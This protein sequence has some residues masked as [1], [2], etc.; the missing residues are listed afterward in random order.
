[1]TDE[2]SVYEDL[3]ASISNKACDVHNPTSRRD[4]F[5]PGR[6]TFHILHG[7]HRKT[8]QFTPQ[9]LVAFVWAQTRQTPGVNIGLVVTGERM[10]LMIIDRIRPI[11]AECDHEDIQMVYRFNQD[12]VK[13]KNNSELTFV[14]CESLRSRGLKS[15]ITIFQEIVSRDVAR[16]R[17]YSLLVETT[18]D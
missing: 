1:M 18:S 6:E 11:V 12:C 9:E 2:K 7:V 15:D 3:N 5:L 17:V 10:K 14:G 4:L 16:S 13:F 8:I